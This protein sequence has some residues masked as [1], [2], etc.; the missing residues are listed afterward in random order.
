MGNAEKKSSTKPIGVAGENNP[1]DGYLVSKG[2]AW[3]IFILLYALY[4]FDF[5]DRQV[6]SALFP[7]LKKEWNLSDTQLGALV[8]VVNVSIAIVVFPVAL[9]IDR[10]SRKKSLAIMGILWSLATIACAFTRNFSQLFVARAFIGTGE[11]GYAS[12][13]AP[14]IAAN[15]PEKKR[16]TVL[17]LINSGAYIGAII[18]VMLG[19]WIAV[20]WGWRY[21]FGIVGIPGLIIAVAFFFIRDYKTVPLEITDKKSSLKVK[22]TGKQMVGAFISTPSLIMTYLGCTAALIFNAT[23]LNWV[24]SF[25]N[26]F[27]GLPM[28][29]AGLYAAGMMIFSAVGMVLGGWIVDKW[30]ARWSRAA[31]VGPALF[32]LVTAV[33]NVLAFGVVRGPL[34]YPV[35]VLGSLM[36]GAIMG[37]VY[38][39][40][41]TLIHPGMRGI[42][43]SLNVVFINLFG[44]AV[45]PLLA[46]LISDR[47]D[48][49]TALAILAF[50]PLLGTLFF[51]I[52]ANFYD[53]D[54]A[55]TEHVQ[56]VVE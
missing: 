13:A 35:I 47:Y 25:F 11:G 9:V 2:Y 8:S 31:L 54:A 46:G 1:Q 19:G 40:T 20:R 41:Q 29:K 43:A 17:G 52:G 33:I 22:M 18:G 10:W 48:I 5:V 3:L 23:L 50:M 44:M 15:F 7:Y 32:C 14:L 24:P 49:Q 21:A 39:A 36:L 26:R 34:Q 27:F 38:S 53:R 56:L 51:L 28:D 30:R 12:A 16:A 6:I 42:S 4:V 55:N 45:G 37:P